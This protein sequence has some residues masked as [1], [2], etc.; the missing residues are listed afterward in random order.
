MTT[1]KGK[2]RV[3]CENRRA[4]FDYELLE[5][6]EAGLV[7][8]GPEVKSLRKGDAHL[9]DA[10]VGFEGN[11]LVLFKAHIAP[12]EQANRENHDPL[13]P[14]PLLL[15]REELKKLRNR[16]RERGLTLIPTKIYF[17]GPW[18]KVSF[19]VGRGRKEHDKRHAIRE[20]EDRREV[21]RAIRG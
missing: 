18:A 17:D 15:H 9:N 5:D 1:P 3:I 13:R 10:W 14:R 8:L 6:F 2:I 21:Q 20:R 4:R 7:L 11:H 19:S 16:V 12:Y